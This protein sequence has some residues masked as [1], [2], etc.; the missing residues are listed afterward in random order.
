MDEM[1]FTAII[2]G[3]LR[4]AYGEYL[5]FHPYDLPFSLRIPNEIIVK[6]R[7]AIIAL[8]KL[9]GKTSDMEPLE[10]DMFLR[11][12]TLK[13]SSSSSSIEGTHTTVDD[14]YR[15]EKEKPESE[16]NIRDAQEVLNYKKALELGMWKIKSTGKIDVSLMNE[17]H[18]I[19]MTGVRG[20]NK[21]PGMFRETQNLIGSVKD[22]LESAKMVPPHPDEI[23]HLIDNLISF[24]DS[25]EEPML[26]IALVHYQFECI[27]PY[28]DGNGRLGRLLILLM[29][30]KEDIL[31]HPA[32]YPSEYFNRRRTEY[33]ERLHMVSHHD[34]F[35]EWL[36]FFLDA[37]IEQSIDSVNA[38]DELRAY[39]KKLMSEAD[40]QYEKDVITALF[41]NPY[42]RA[43]DVM[44]ICGV[45]NPT[46]NKIIN[47][48]V[49]KGVLRET[50]GRRRSRLYREDTIL[51]ILGRRGRY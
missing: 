22:T 38:M 45:T 40:N 37:M 8:S 9:D 30:A 33:I 39:K 7:T 23:E 44:H 25:G 28:R 29:L 19:L 15:Y 21:S 27:H 49:K 32:I 1:D 48:L 46:A 10:R 17:M 3:E 26:K 20:E 50:T 14:L 13:E 6:C 11:A 47:N 51:E 16:N 24:I 18:K 31:T 34:E 43:A 42:I 4:S 41:T 5:Y 12:F 36:N 2:S 35:N